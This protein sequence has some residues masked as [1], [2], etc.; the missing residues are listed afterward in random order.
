MN[1]KILI[2]DDV[3]T[4][5][6]FVANSLLRETAYE[7][8]LTAVANADEAV[9]AVENIEFDLIL[10]DVNMPG[11]NGF[12]M[13]EAMHKDGLATGTPLIF[14]SA[15]E[16]V[17]DKLRGF[18]CGAIDFMNKPIDPAILRSKI[19]AAVDIS[20]AQKDLA[21]EH[22]LLSKTTMDVINTLGETGVILEFTRSLF[23]IDDARA[24]TKA[25]TKTLDE[26]GLSAVVRVKSDEDILY[27]NTAEGPVPELE[28]ELLTQLEH[29]PRIYERGKRIIFNYNEI[30]MFIKSAPDSDDVRARYRDILAL[31]A[32]SAVICLKKSNLARQAKLK[33]LSN[34]AVVALDSVQSQRNANKAEMATIFDDLTIDL[35]SSVKRIGLTEDQEEELLNI[36]HGGIDRFS[37]AMAK[38]RVIE[39]KLASL[40]DQFV[41][42]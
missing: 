42:A 25:I 1:P 9:D 26:L 13:A 12:E 10:S 32:D 19:R 20:R 41:R 2:V 33:S 37:A 5:R 16:T 21:Q 22:E 28:R 29:A 18:E 35:E 14:L 7:Y 38:D 4:E 23:G 6:E 31:M 30:L 24:L 39:R 27:G 36:V 15:L 8:E 11:L 3:D 17:E 40:L 34:D